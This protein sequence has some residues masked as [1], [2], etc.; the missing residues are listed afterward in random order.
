MSIHD[1]V[2]HFNIGGLGTLLIFDDVGIRPR[3]LDNQRDAKA[4]TKCG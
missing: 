1:A 4:K 3:I 2:I